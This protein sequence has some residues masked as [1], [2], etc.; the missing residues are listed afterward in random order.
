[1]DTIFYL[2]SF[3]FDCFL[4]CSP[5]S[6]LAYLVSCHVSC[7]VLCLRS[8]YAF[9]LYA[10][11][12]LSTYL[13]LFIAY[14]LV[15]CLCLYRY[16]HLVRTHGARAWSPRRKQKG[17]RFKHVDMSQAAMF[18]IFRGLA[19]PIWLCTLSSPLSSSPSFSL[20]WVVLGISCHVLLV[21]ISRVWQPL[22]NFL[23][24][25]FGSCFKDVG[26]YFLALCAYI[27]HDVCIYTCLP[28]LV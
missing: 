15:S 28:L 20:R 23:H 6:L 4:V 27:M 2:L 3:L 10:H 25:Y 9:L 14:L 1:M 17:C 7:H 11:C 21:L 5:S 26:I 24:L 13:F 8:L 22:F 16:T 18:S 12:A 19:S